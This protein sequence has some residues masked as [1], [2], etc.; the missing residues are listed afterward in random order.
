MPEA[1]PRFQAV[2]GFLVRRRPAESFGYIGMVSV[3]SLLVVD[4]D[5]A[6]H[7]LLNTTLSREGRSI[8]NAYDG[9]EAL[10]PSGLGP[11]TW[12]WRAQART[13]SM[14]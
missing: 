12:C 10:D 5:P 13:G 2:P 14:A 8:Q 9:R 3:R 7:E 4:Q 11:V 6:V 1:G